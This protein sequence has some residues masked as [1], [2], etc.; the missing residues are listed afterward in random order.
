MSQL[1]EIHE[2]V[3]RSLRDEAGPLPS[4]FRKIA[5]AFRD[6]EFT[7]MKPEEMQELEL[8]R[9]HEAK[10]E[11]RETADRRRSHRC[12]PIRDGRTA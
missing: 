5:E 11:T 6:R 7:P 10:V 1:Q 2:S 8:R 9:A 12:H 4:E 3:C